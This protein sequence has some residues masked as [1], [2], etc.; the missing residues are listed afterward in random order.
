VAFLV[1]QG[2]FCFGE[3]VSPNSGAVI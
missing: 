2:T 3:I 1:E